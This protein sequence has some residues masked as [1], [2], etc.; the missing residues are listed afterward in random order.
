MKIAL[1]IIGSLLIGIAILFFLYGT[2]KMSKAESETTS[3]EIAPDIKV[4]EKSS[5]SEAVAA[6][7]FSAAA[8][9]GVLGIV[10]I[11][12]SGRAT[13]KDPE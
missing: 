13:K 2:V 6:K 7:G 3:F 11:L 10:L 9:S 8:V 12:F 4:V 5:K 1:R